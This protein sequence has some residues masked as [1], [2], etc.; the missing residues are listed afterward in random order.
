MIYQS[1]LIIVPNDQWEQYK[2]TANILKW[3]IDHNTLF[4]YDMVNGWYYTPFRIIKK[5]SVNQ[6]KTD[7]NTLWDNLINDGVI[8]YHEPTD[9]IRIAK[10]FQIDFS[11][12]IKSTMDKDNTYMI[13][14]PKSD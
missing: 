14:Q 4:H 5:L 11:D 6:D 3:L 1:K 12:V 8:E 2:H 7:V 13:G 10:I 9:M